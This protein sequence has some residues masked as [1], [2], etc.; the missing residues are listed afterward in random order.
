MRSEPG[1]K[2]SPVVG[3]ESR[4]QRRT[5]RAP[6]RLP[7]ITNFPIG[8]FPIGGILKIPASV[9]ASGEVKGSRDV[10]MRSWG[11]IKRAVD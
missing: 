10:C 1:V 6:T 2:D 7:F 3:R 9:G 5:S 11:N 8:I 4:A